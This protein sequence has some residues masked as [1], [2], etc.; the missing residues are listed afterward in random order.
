M[1]PLIWT[2][3]VFHFLHF[4]RNYSTFLLF[5][6]NLIHIEFEYRTPEPGS[7]HTSESASRLQSLPLRT[8]RVVRSSLI[9]P[10]FGSLSK[11]M[12]TMDDQ[13]R[14]L[15][16]QIGKHLTNFKPLCT[17]VRP[18]FMHSKV[19]LVNILTDSL[20]ARFKEASGTVN[21]LFADSPYCMFLD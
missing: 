18:I 20:L 8:L 9:H 16:N 21:N 14:L 2:A 12:N 5:K 6:N 15:K 17:Q 7:R 3:I 13:L 1:F 11:I 10:A 4:T 19:S